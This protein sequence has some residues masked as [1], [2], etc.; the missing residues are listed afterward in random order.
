MIAICIPD[1]I[2]F[3]TRDKEG[4]SNYTS[5]YLSEKN[6]NPKLK[7]IGIHVFTAALLTIAKT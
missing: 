1:K 2:D 7:N 6:Q 3:K 4:P 5:G